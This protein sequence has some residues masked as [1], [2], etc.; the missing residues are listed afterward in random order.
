VRSLRGTLAQKWPDSNGD[1]YHATNP[2]V[3]VRADGSELVMT[4]RPTPP[5]KGSTVY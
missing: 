5:P 4:Y 2:Y 1:L 3:R